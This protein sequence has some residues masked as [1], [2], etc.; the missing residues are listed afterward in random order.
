MRIIL[1]ATLVLVGA[2]PNH[3]VAGAQPSRLWYDKPAKKWTEA[4]P[5]GNGR[6][7]GM[8]FGG[9]EKERVQFNECTLWLGEPHDYSHPGAA[10]HLPVI[11]QLLFEGKQ[12]E[13]EALALKN[14]MSIPLRQMPY[15]P[16]GDVFLEFPGHE[17]AQGVQEFF[18]AV[19]RRRLSRATRLVMP[20]M[21]SSRSSALRMPSAR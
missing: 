13:A 8:V 11:R 5:V 17:R 1:L 7:G 16:F 6:I 21:R 2:M 3:W 12:K 9:L 15:Q 18:G 14:F 10:E 20:W 4:L 19:H